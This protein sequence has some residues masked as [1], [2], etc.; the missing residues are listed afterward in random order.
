MSYGNI[1][2]LENQVNTQQKEVQQQLETTKIEIEKLKQEQKVK[3]EKIAFLS[4]ELQKHKKIPD[5]TLLVSD[6]LQLLE[7][8]IT[9]TKNLLGNF[10]IHQ[11]SDR[12]QKSQVMSK[13]AILLKSRNKEMPLRK[14]QD[15][16]NKEFNQY[17]DNSPIISNINRN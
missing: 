2:R 15:I 17:S 11:M 5:V 1:K 13:S 9:D 8:V 4:E 7:K 14:I 12:R 16:L 3:E 10:P 6:K